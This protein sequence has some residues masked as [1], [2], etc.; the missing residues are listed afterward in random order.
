MGSNCVGLNT[1]FSEVVAVGSTELTRSPKWWNEGLLV[2]SKL[3][4]VRLG[5]LADVDGLMPD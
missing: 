1:S 5:S 3:P 4:W 2:T